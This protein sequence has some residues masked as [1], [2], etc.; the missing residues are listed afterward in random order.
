VFFA[1]FFASRTASRTGSIRDWKSGM[2]IGKRSVG[3]TFNQPYPNGPC[4]RPPPV[5]FRCSTSCST[6]ELGKSGDVMAAASWCVA[7]C[8]RAR[9]L[10]DTPARSASEHRC[11]S[12]AGLALDAQLALSRGTEPV[13]TRGRVPWLKFDPGPTS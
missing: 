3:K 5:A 7:S 10:R 11:R 13:G 1:V 8:P 9:T 6:T 12:L 2:G 4:P